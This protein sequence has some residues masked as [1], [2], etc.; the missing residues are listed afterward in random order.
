MSS[1][2]RV[3]SGVLDAIAGA[4]SSVFGWVTICA[5]AVSLLTVGIKAVPLCG[6]D[7]GPVGAAPEPESVLEPAL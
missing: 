6:D 1:H 7:D 4:T 3:L 5:V 2:R